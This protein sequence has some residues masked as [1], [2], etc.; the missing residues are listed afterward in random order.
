[1]IDAFLFVVRLAGLADVEE[2]KKSG[3]VGSIDQSPFAQRLDEAVGNHEL[4]CGNGAGVHAE[5]LEHGCETQMLP[6]FEGE[7]CGPEFHD[8]GGLD[9][10]ENNA[11]DSGL[12]NWLGGLRA[13]CDLN[14]AMSEH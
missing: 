8:I 10:I 4:G 12:G 5:G 2:F 1:L 14:D 9:G 6:S 7:E 11:I 13:S 3:A